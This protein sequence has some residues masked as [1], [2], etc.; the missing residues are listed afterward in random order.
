M[1][2]FT[3]RD[4][5]WLTIVVA[6]GIGWT[7]EHT[8]L[9]G[10]ARETWSWKAK[11][12]KALEEVRQVHKRESMLNERVF[13]LEH[14]AAREGWKVIYGELGGTYARHAS[15]GDTINCP[16]RGEKRPTFGSGR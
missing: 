8:Q 15:S 2:Q 7:I 10:P 13:C 5:L 4:L 14:I 9:S 6:V 16:V 1:L 3:V 12:D 11:H